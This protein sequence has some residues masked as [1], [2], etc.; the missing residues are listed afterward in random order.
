MAVDAQMSQSWWI[1]IR[2]TE[3]VRC[4]CLSRSGCG[5]QLGRGCGCRAARSVRQ[6]VASGGVVCESVAA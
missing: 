1:L 2:V 5:H 3:G 4:R 6:K